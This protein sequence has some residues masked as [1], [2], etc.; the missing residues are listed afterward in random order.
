MFK[1]DHITLNR[2]L[3]LYD[4]NK[5]PVIFDLC[6]SNKFLSHHIIENYIGTYEF[7]TTND[8]P[9]LITKNENSIKIDIKET[10]NIIMRSWSFKDKVLRICVDN[11]TISE[12][13][14]NYR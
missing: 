11:S 1:P 5:G 3:T 12:D 8:E 6:L 7:N 9:T 4:R 13:K 10:H 14:I 2:F